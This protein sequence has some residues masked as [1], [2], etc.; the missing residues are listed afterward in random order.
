MFVTRSLVLG[1]LILLL[2]CA[3]V[4]SVDKNLS[5]TLQAGKEDEEDIGSVSPFNLEDVFVFKSTP[6]SGYLPVT[7]FCS[8]ATGIPSTH[9]VIREV[10][11]EYSSIRQRKKS[12]LVVQV[13]RE[14]IGTHHG[15]YTD[16][17]GGISWTYVEGEFNG[18]P[19][20]SVGSCSGD[21]AR[22]PQPGAAPYTCRYALLQ[23]AGYVGGNFTFNGMGT[24]NRGYL[25]SSL[26]TLRA[27][28][29]P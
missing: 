4:S 1:T 27:W 23:M 7:A 22:A 25:S 13:D 16:T 18:K 8:N 2:G 5:T 6:T 9:T 29:Q 3:G 20:K 24:T 28:K 11:Y 12:G 17:V 26:G 19:F 15:C 14:I 21:V 10:T